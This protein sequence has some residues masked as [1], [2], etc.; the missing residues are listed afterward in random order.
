MHDLELSVEGVVELIPAIPYVVME[1]SYAVEGDVLTAY[2]TRFLLVADGRLIELG[3]LMA[4]MGRQGLDQ[5]DAETADAALVGTLNLLA[6][7]GPLITELVAEDMR[8]EP[9]IASGFSVQDQRLTFR[10]GEFA[11]AVFVR[12]GTESTA[13]QTKSW[14]QLKG[15]ISN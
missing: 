9:L 2:T 15:W 14:G 3:Q 13:V 5:L 7:S 1:G 6:E 12:D 4:D 8:E 10:E 11:G